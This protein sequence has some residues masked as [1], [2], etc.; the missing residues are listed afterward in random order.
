MTDYNADFT[1]AERDALLEARAAFNASAPGTAAFNTALKDVVAALLSM[2]IDEPQLT[3]TDR[4]YSRSLNSEGFPVY[5]EYRHEFLMGI[6]G[7]YY[8]AWAY[9]HSAS[10]AESADMEPNL[11]ERVARGRVNFPY[12]EENPEIV[13]RS[14]LRR[15]LREQRAGETF[16]TPVIAK[17]APA[18][19]LSGSVALWLC[20][21]SCYSSRSVS[22]RSLVKA[23]PCA[24]ASSASH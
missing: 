1:K 18:T 15:G 5:P 19:R 24:L 6:D 20:R 4:E 10:F 11:W 9:E 12:R 2:A 22:S 14:L 23:K 21:R 3:A 17:Y 8:A 13:D 7:D 16:P